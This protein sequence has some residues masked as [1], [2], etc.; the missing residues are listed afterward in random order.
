[1]W[2]VSFTDQ[3]KWSSET[4]TTCL[5]SHS[6]QIAIMKHTQVCVAPYPG[7]STFH[8]ASMFFFQIPLS[9]TLKPEQLK[10]I[11]WLNLPAPS[12]RTHI[13]FSLS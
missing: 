13:C 5:K 10:A 7:N 12:T 2:P 8:S 9:P 3:E 4:E 11:I 6:P 1:M